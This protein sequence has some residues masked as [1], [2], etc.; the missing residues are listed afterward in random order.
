MLTVPAFLFYAPKPILLYFAGW[1]GGTLAA[2]VD[3]DICQ[4]SAY[5]R[6]H[7]LTYRCKTLNCLQ[8]LHW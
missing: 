5:K 8:Q 3:P 1:S 4:L 7:W 6:P 2:H